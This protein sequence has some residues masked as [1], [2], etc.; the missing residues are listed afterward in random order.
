MLPLQ[1]VARQCRV[2]PPLLL[3]SSCCSF[4]VVVIV[5]AAG[6]HVAP[7]HRR[8]PGV[9]STWLA[10]TRTSCSFRGTWRNSSPTAGP[11][12]TTCVRA[13]CV[14][15]C[16]R[17]CTRLLL[18]PVSLGHHVGASGSLARWL[19]WLPDGLVW[20]GRFACWSSACGRRRIISVHAWAL[21]HRLLTGAQS[22]ARARR[23]CG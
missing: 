6:R 7:P 20:G 15:A 8:H 22:Q 14:P 10:W 12:L 19:G 17:A 21:S 5:V 9:W 2:V 13:F 18:L 23:P 3:Q 11:P 16:L 4:V 1:A